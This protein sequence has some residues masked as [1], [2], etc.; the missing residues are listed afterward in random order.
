MVT[1]LLRAAWLLLALAW[2]VPAAAHPS[3]SSLVVLS[4]GAHDI[5]A[6]VT[7]PLDELKLAL[8][9]DAQLGAYLAAHIRPVAPDGR[10][11]TVKVLDVRWE[12]ARQPADVI[13]TVLL[14]PPPGA[15]LGS[16]D[17]ELDA[18]A[19]QV[20]NHTT[21]VALRDR[22]QGP[23]AQPR[24]LASLAY[25]HR[26]VAVR[27]IVPPW[28]R[29]FGDLFMLGMRHIA[30]GADHLL[31]LFT[32]LLPAG[33]VAHERRW[34]GFAGGA[35]LARHLLAVVSA[36]TFGHSLTLLLGAAGLAAPPAQPVEVAIALSIML[37]AAHAWAPVF[38]RREAWIAGAFG[39]VHGLAFSAAL[40]ALQLEG[41][42]LAAGVLAFNLG[43]EAVQ[44]GLLLATVPVLVLLART[45][46]HERVRQGAAAAAMMMALV[47]L[48]Q[49]VAD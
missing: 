9:Q 30:E 39:L 38:P 25:G 47:W 41:A 45:R 10:A 19:H 36:F 42:R 23:D 43:I 4:A 6:D 44:V 40:R 37:S 16:F 11:W 32:L 1:F 46:H 33:L 27:D 8:S 22:A 13:A 29:G 31:F 7:L 18:I 20:P 17:L 15:P 14:R 48:V 12:R 3:A 2:A 28:W 35:A 21:L 34:G 5:R 49:R 24:M 26:S